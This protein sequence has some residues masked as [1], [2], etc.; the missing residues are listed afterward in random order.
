MAINSRAKGNRAM[1]YV[2]KSFQSWW[3]GVWQRR[4]GGFSGDD[5]IPPDGFPFSVEVKDVATVK[6]RHFLE[7]TRE[8]LG[9]WRQAMD[10]SIAVGKQPLLVLK[11]ER[12]WFVVRHL[13]PLP[14]QASAGFWATWNGYP[15]LILPLEK[16]FE[17]HERTDPT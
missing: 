2:V 6:V 15:V 13:S 9:Y 3:G 14:K 11:A 12:S 4:G 1:T 8:L 10:Q 16:F 17:C 5:L 7:P